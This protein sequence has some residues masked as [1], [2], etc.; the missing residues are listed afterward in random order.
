MLEAPEELRGVHVILLRARNDLHKLASRATKSANSCACENTLNAAWAT[1][2]L[3]QNQLRALRTTCKQL[4]NFWNNH[5]PVA[6]FEKQH[7]LKQAQLDQDIQDALKRSEGNA[8]ETESDA[9]NSDAS[10]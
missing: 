9:E 6:G 7:K 8:D 10:V 1:A 3:R 5:T 2:R 4:L